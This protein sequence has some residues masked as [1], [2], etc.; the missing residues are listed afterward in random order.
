[1]PPLEVLLARDANRTE[2]LGRTEMRA[3]WARDYVITTHKTLSE[4]DASKFDCIID[5]S[6]LSTKEIAEK[7]LK[8]TK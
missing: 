4:M 6:V 2:R 3:N 5:S 7:V 1:M 8:L